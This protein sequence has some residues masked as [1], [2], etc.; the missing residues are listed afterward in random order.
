[1]YERMLEE[2][3][4]QSDLEIKAYGKEMLRSIAVALRPLTIEELAIGC[5][6]ARGDVRGY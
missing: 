2:L 4:S 3:E 1:M 6:L 5:G